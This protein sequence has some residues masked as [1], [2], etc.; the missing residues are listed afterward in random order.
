ML[1]DYRAVHNLGRPEA[2]RTMLSSRPVFPP[3]VFVHFIHMG[4]EE[5]LVAV[6]RACATALAEPRGFLL[7]LCLA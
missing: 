5:V 2:T 3:Q 4:Q 1:G 7:R 6:S